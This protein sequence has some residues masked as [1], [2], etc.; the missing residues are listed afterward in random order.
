MEYG[1]ALG[2]H[3]GIDAAALRL[4]RL[5]GLAQGLGVRR[6]P[7]GRA[8]GVD[9]DV[10]GLWRIGVGGDAQGLPFGRAGDGMGQYLAQRLGQRF[11]GGGQG[12]RGGAQLQLERQA[13]AF[14]LGAEFGRQVF[15][16]VAHVHG[17]WWRGGG[18]RGQGRGGRLRRSGRW[19]RGRRWFRGGGGRLRP[20]AL[21]R[22]APGDGSGQG[23]QRQPCAE[24]GQR[25]ALG[26]EPALQAR[27]AGLYRQGHQR[28][29]RSALPGDPFDGSGAGD[30]RHA[31]GRCRLCRQV[32]GEQR[33]AVQAAA[34][35]QGG[36]ARLRQQA[37]VRTRQQHLGAGRAGV[38]QRRR[39]GE[40]TGIE[41]GDEQGVGLGG[42]PHTPHQ[43]QAVRTAGAQGGAP[44]LQGLRQQRTQINTL[45][46]VGRG[47]RGQHQALHVHQGQA[48][49]GRLAAQ[50]LVLHGLK[51]AP[52]V[53]GLHQVGGQLVERAL[54][55]FEHGRS[56]GLGQ[57]RQ[58]G[59][60]L[61]LTLLQL[62]LG[63]PQQR[64]APRAHGQK[65]R[66][67]AS[68]DAGAGGVDGAG[69]GGG[70]RGGVH[71]GGPSKRVG[72]V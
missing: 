16:Q 1:A 38:Q 22:T 61:A 39:R 25:L 34:R 31:V 9:G 52:G 63:M 71:V 32:G 13:L 70:V 29:G 33:V 4:Q 46:Q 42:Q 37:A 40:R 69:P 57:V 53:R 48:A 49:Q 67:A 27:R 28:V 44:V 45:A 62:G 56:M 59:Q 58:Q 50:R 55:G 51:A 65:Q 18:G 23:Q 3:G 15:Q 21:P 47:G 19:W 11:G 10:Q 68:Q 5:V 60:L 2:I 17:G 14:E 7:G 6:G 24:A 54:A 36:G 64:Q 66:Q 20:R 35:G 30:L 41:L 72:A 12:Q 43:G 8:V 26:G